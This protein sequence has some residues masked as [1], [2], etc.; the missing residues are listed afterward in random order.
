M[1]RC[2]IWNTLAFVLNL[3][4]LAFK[5]YGLIFRVTHEERKMVVGDMQLQTA[6]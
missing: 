4:Q 1:N 5:S 6:L 2:S 3:Y